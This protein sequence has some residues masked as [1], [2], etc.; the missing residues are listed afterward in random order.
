MSAVSCRLAEWFC[1]G[2]LA[3]CQAGG[4][5]VMG[6][7]VTHQTCSQGSVMVPGE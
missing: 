1:F 3:H 7:Y 2:G 5:G 6:P 4:I